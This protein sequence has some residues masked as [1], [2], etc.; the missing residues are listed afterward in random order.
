MG[1]GDNESE[2]AGLKG[3]ITANSFAG[4]STF[5]RRRSG[6]AFEAAD[7]VVYGLPFDLGVSNRPGARFGPRAIRE[8]S[9]Q[10]S[11]G[12]VWPWGFDPFEHLAV[13]DAGDV[14]YTYGD[15]DGFQR[16]AAEQAKAIAQA[17]AKPFSLGG[18]HGV[19]LHTLTGLTQVTGPVALLHFDAHTDTSEGPEVQHGTMFRHSERL[20]ITVGRNSIQVGIRTNYEADDDYLRIHAPDVANDDPAVTA[21]TICE[22]IGEMPCYVSF[23]IDCLD[24]SYAPGTGTPVPGGVSTLRILEIFRALG[25]L[26]RDRPLNF[27]GFDLVEVAPCYD[28]AQMTSLAAA[29]IAQELL[30]LVA[31]PKRV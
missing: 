25:H 29:Q 30:C 16:A 17:G 3:R 26:M 13:L 2:K 24:P 23:D 27:V 19:T 31:A 6:T 1:E 14:D 20:G 11:W 10:L 8:A 5:F 28:S 12:P 21:K 9:L 4:P 7:I 18:D 15:V 22:R